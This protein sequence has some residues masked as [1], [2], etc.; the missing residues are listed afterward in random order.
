MPILRIMRCPALL[1]VALASWTLLAQNG[2]KAGEV[3]SEVVPPDKIP[4]APILSPRDQIKTF[5]LPPGFR[6]EI[7]A[8]EPLITSP[9]AVQFDHQGR[10][11]VV[12]M[13]GYMPNP[14]GTGE[15]APTGNIVILED[16][17][18]DGQMD[19]R[20]VFLE[21]LVMPRS[22]MLFQ[23]GALVAEPPRVWFARDTNGD[24]KADEKEVVIEDF[25]TANDPK[26][27]A[28]SNPEH[29]SNSLTWALDNWIYAANHTTRFR[30]TD[31]LWKREPTIFR[32][33]WGLTQDDYGRLYYNSN[34]D[35]LRADSVPSKYLSRNPNLRNPT[36]ANVQIERDLRVYPSRVNPGVN[37]G[38]QPKQLTPEGKLATFT[39]ACGPVV[40]RGDQFPSEF[41]GNTFLC[42]PTANLI[43][44]EIISD[45]DGWL[46]ATNAYDK[47]EFLTSTDERFRPVN[48]VNGPDGCLYVVDMARGLI[49]H[50]IYLTS[51]LRKQI[52]SRNLQS[53]VNLGRIYR[54]VHDSKPRRTESLPGK[55]SNDALLAKLNHPN[56]WWRDRAQ[57]M[58]VQ[59]RDNEVVAP[60]KKL[61][62][63]R[64]NPSILGRL[65]ALWTLDGLGQM[66]LP[67]LEKGLSDPSPKVRTHAIR[68]S[69][70]F[71]SSEDRE[72]AI[73]LV[74]RRAGVGPLEE[75]LQMILTLGEIATPAGD[76]ITKLLL[77]NS[78]ASSLR[79][80]A[81]ISGLTGRELEFLTSFV[82]DPLCA[83]GKQE[84]AAL[85]SGLSRA[86][87]QERRT[88]RVGQLLELTAF[89]KTGDWQ[90]LAMLDGIAGSVPA[91]QKDKP[92]SGIKPIRFDKEPKG[93]AA[94]KTLSQPE[95]SQRV[96]RFDPLLVWPGKPG[97][98]E[99]PPP[100]ALS[101]E[102][103]KS[104]ERGREL[105][106]VVCSACHQPTGLGQDGL[107]PP[108]ADSEWVVGSPQRLVRIVLHGVRDALVVK[109]QRWNLSMP[110][111]GPGLDDQQIADV[112]TYLRREW[113]HTASPI[114]S[115]VVRSI[116]Q[117]SGNRED[118]WTS[119]EL[120][121]LP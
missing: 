73:N 46:T 48:L 63:S 107:A 119:P 79:F 41:L 109:G 118:A 25:A 56:G 86:V 101:A 40:Y 91:P 84:H 87:I 95:I 20:T 43:R 6:A 9:V 52:E 102:Q 111:L 80:D 108:L 82:N 97:W 10:I 44:R 106:A 29:A 39:G 61:A 83:V 90:Q 112:L 47:A 42:E 31:G 45:T 14:E 93:L 89:R 70:S 33:Q 113:E 59:R 5:S 16:T 88:P 58:L 69:E 62:D 19:R 28:K 78:P 49:Q 85:L 8:A 66:D 30:T 74:L 23:D 110:A 75:Q 50:R 71:F 7:V 94:L 2:D 53:P 1:S 27:G 17:N 115:D 22:I 96:T 92:V 35:P 38:Y 99:P 116:R 57:Q 67:T 34:S 76:T 36:G 4:P 54:I 105:Y 26:L 51:Y 100:P 103:Q 15:Q 114:D 68:M 117:L 65:H 32:G 24:G 64:S 21:G 121:K 72:D 11:W 13:N 37:R 60:L 120:E 104:F 18:G 55:P 98:V 12:E 3:Q 77:M 81:A